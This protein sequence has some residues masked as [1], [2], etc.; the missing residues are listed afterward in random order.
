MQLGLDPERLF[1]V[2]GTEIPRRVRP[3]RQKESS[4]VTETKVPTL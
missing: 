3:P 4:Q 2:G 1:F